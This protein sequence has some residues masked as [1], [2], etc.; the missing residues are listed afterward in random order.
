MFKVQDFKI[1][2][3][4]TSC[5]AGLCAQYVPL[6]CVRHKVLVMLLCCVMYSRVTVVTVLQL[7]VVL[8][9]GAALLVAHVIC[10][11][12]LDLCATVHLA[13]SDAV[14]CLLCGS[15]MVHATEAWL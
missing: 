12:Q 1:S 2:R 11:R 6:G 15:V 10:L 13:E 14:S 7:H 3:L 9:S 4:S 8:M 5:S